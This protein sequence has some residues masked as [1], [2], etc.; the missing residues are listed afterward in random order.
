M[1]RNVPAG[2]ILVGSAT[3]P[4]SSCNTPMHHELVHVKVSHQDGIVILAFRGEIDSNSVIALHAVLDQLELDA[5]VVLDMSD[6]RFMDSS[7][8]N[9]VLAQSVRM[10]RA[11]GSI[12][13][14][15]PS[16][17]VRR[18]LEIS[19]LGAVL[20]ETDD[21]RRVTPGGQERAAVLTP[22]LH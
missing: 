12:H 5:N 21:P 8:L 15:Q 2:T 22:E 3:R 10:G 9:A 20:L 18:V 6:V 1:T 19:G 13:I 4:A 11:S 14:V 7:G 16:T 17:A